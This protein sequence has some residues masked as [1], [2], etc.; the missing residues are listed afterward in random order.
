MKQATDLPIFADVDMALKALRRSFQH[1]EQHRRNAGVHALPGVEPE[2]PST[3]REREKQAAKGHVVEPSDAFSLM[4]QYAI[5]TADY[6][7]VLDAGEAIS[8]ARRIGYPVAL[9]IASTEVLHKTE[10]G[11]VKL[12]ISGDETL[13]AALH[14]MKGGHSFMVQKMA[15]PGRELIV[16]AKIDAEFGPVLMLGLGGIFAEILKHVSMKVL[17]ID[18]T[19]A[20]GMIDELRGAALL[21]GFRGERA[22][23]LEAL[24]DA[25]LAVSQLCME[26][27]DVTNL[28]INPLI[29]YEKGLGCV[30]VD[31]KLERIDRQRE[32]EG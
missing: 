11:G 14:G 29:V 23:D 1:W 16:G 30:A 15:L 25:L 5:P 12:N 3:K 22:A 2:V 10:E 32:T 28:D 21:K 24:E 27:R 6:E 19:I 7:F 26:Q 13:E 8:A 9:K 4:K 18:R 17:P 20:R 31:V